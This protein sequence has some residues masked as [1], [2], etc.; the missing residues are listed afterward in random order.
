MTDLRFVYER[1]FSDSIEYVLKLD[2]T[3]LIVDLCLAHDLNRSIIGGIG[4]SH[5]YRHWNY[6]KFFW[7]RICRNPDGKTI[8]FQETMYFHKVLP[9]F[10]A[11][12]LTDVM[13][14]AEVKVEEV[15]GLKFADENAQ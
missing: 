6:E 15:I 4:K 1:E 8:S 5:K 13:L 14:A 2:D 9:K 11:D 12:L 10:G 7:L 3:E